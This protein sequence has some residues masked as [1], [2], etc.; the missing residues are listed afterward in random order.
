ML[1][2]FFSQLHVLSRA[3]AC[4]VWH[5]VQSGLHIIIMIKY[6]TMGAGQPPLR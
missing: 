6:E 5:G 3:I 4:L 1:P 2:F